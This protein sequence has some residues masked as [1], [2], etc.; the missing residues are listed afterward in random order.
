MPGE[1]L[2]WQ[3]DVDSLGMDD[4][5][6]GDQLAG[7]TV[8]VSFSDGTS[9]TGILAAVAGNPDAAQ[10]DLDHNSAGLDRWE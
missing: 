10:V 4:V 5:V 7:A 8:S 1:S 6:T 3:V 2:T 9:A